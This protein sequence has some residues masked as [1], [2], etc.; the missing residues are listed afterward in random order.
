MLNQRR[1]NQ[2]L[3]RIVYV[4]EAAAPC[5]THELARILVV[6]RNN[7]QRDGLTGVVLHHEGSFLQLL[8]G[9][10]ET[11]RARFA[12]IVEDPRHRKV[13]VLEIA[14]V[15]ERIFG[16]W[17]MGSLD[18][19]ALDEDA[20]EF[21]SRGREGI[22]N[23]PRAI[24]RLL[25]GFRDGRYKKAVRPWHQPAVASQGSWVVAATF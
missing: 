20:S 21:L 4:S 9:P 14:D 18:P 25:S 2:P 24:A 22:V 19:S 10:A 23:Q 1:V 13:T 3:L 15:A 6:A 5:S 12:D 16:A 7:N 11:V 17:T 8:E